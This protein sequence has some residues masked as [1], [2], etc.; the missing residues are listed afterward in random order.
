[1]LRNILHFKKHP[2]REALH[3]LLYD[4]PKGLSSI[5]IADRLNISDGECNDLLRLEQIRDAIDVDPYSG[6]LIYKSKRKIRPKFSLSKA[7][8]IARHHQ[9]MTIIKIASTL[10]AVTLI[11]INIS[12]ITVNFGF[13]GKAPKEKQNLDEKSR[14]SLVN[15]KLAEQEKSE[16]ASVRDDLNRRINDMMAVVISGDCTSSWGE[17]KTCYIEG[18]LLN[19]A[20]VE[21]ELKE[22]KLEVKKI[23]EQ[24][25]SIR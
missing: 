14:R 13:P 22:M 12:N 19:K 3:T 1:M 10:F 16:L 24:Y 20:E 21:S 7:I 15:K 23:Q 8:A 5:D 9:A 18:R 11:S 17:D 25:N 4:Y 2:Y 6:T